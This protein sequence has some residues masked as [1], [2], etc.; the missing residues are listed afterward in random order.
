MCVCV[1]VSAWWG[2]MDR[3]EAAGLGDSIRGLR[4]LRG[5]LREASSVDAVARRWRGI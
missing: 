2:L 5:L 1:R 3:F 4:R